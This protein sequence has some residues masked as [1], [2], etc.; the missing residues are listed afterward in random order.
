VHFLTVGVRLFMT[1]KA[2]EQALMEIRK[3]KRN[4]ELHMQREKALAELELFRSDARIYD[5]VPCAS[6]PR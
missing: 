2:G 4:A 1:C 5:W 3:A 6:P